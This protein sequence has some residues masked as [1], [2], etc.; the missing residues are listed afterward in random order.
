MGCLLC[1]QE[2]YL[3]SYLQC[4][5]FSPAINTAPCS[6]YNCIYCYSENQCG[7]C[8]PG[9][10]STDGICQTNLFC[11]DDNCEY[12]TNSSYCVSCV[13]KYELVLGA[14]RPQCN[15]SNC[16]S[17]A[18]L[19]TCSQCDDTFI[20]STNKTQCTC[21]DSFV[22]TDG[23]CACPSNSTE[24]EGVCYAC[25]ITNC[26]TCNANNTCLTCADTYILND[27][28]CGCADSSFEI[29]NGKC[30]C[31]SGTLPFGTGEN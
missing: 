29:V 12:C 7:L 20:L 8:A 6:V 23:V 19:T 28:K 24:F 11:S 4:V 18:S 17:C 27:N 22:N 26:S 10:N 9:W 14:C 25:N 13:S 2:Y 3:N 30:A 5:K 31:P 1:S 15:I 16:F 21:K